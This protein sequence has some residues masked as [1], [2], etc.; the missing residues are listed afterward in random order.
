MWKHHR[1][2]GKAVTSL[3]LDV[4]AKKRSSGD[5]GAASRR[6]AAC[7]VSCAQVCGL[8]HGNRPPTHTLASGLAWPAPREHLS[9]ACAEPPR[10]PLASRTWLLL[11]AQEIARQPQL[12]GDHRPLAQ[13]HG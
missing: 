2:Q 8:C 13:S 11:S 5:Q 10:G 12:R 4:S 3:L 6:G 9:R 7:S 1:V